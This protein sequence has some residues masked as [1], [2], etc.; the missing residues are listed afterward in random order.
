MKN[1]NDLI[2]LI[3]AFVLMLGG[4]LTVVFT[5]PKPTQPAPPATVNLAP[6]KIPS[7]DVVYANSL[8]GSTGGSGGGG[9]AGASGLGGAATPGRGR[10]SGGAQ[11]GAGGGR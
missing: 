11:F 4:V 5:A 10:P 6:A 9:A 1:Q 8:P 2:V 7:A 3:T